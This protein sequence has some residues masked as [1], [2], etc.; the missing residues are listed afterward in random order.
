MPDC[1]V[2]TTY[3]GG[4][5]INEVVGRPIPDPLILGP[6]PMQSESDFRQVNGNLQVA[7]EMEWLTDFSQAERIGMTVRLPL[8]QEQARRGFDLVLALGLR[9][10][11]E[12]DGGQRRL[13]S[14]FEGHHY[15]DGLSL[16]PQG[17]PTNNTDDEK[18]GFD[19]VALEET[20]FRVERSRPL[21][22][23]EQEDFRK[24]DGQRLAE[25][26]GIDYGVLQH[27]NYSDGFDLRDAIAM[28][29][30]L[31][32]ASLGYFMEEM[33][34]PVFKLET[35][36]QTRHFFTRFVSGRGALPAIRVG[37]QPYGVLPVSVFSRWRWSKTQDGF[38]D[39]LYQVLKRLDQTWSDLSREVAHAGASADH[40]KELLKILGLQ[41]SSV[42]F[43][44]RFAVGPDYVW[45]W[46]TFSGG[47]RAAPV[48]NRM[49][50]EAAAELLA[51]LGYDFS[52]TPRILNLS[53]LRNQTPLN[54]PLIDDAL[55]SETQRLKPISETIGNY[56]HWLLNSSIDAIRE[57]D[58]GRDNQGNPR[59]PPTALLYLMLRHALTLDYWDV[60]MK[61]HVREKTVSENGRREAELLNMRAQPDVSR[62]DYFELADPQVTGNLKM[63]DFLQTE[64]GSD[65]EEA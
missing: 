14:L 64:R 16:V 41:A 34:R 19:S 29:R 6:D 9:L 20:S 30:A 12:A 37:H 33:M 51:E 52:E 48:W 18:S 32:P 49:L 45:N 15:T 40:E 57:Q 23:V 53:F 3:A 2:I 1:F 4:E 10:S 25:A 35:I 42:E 7:H 38:L 65:I 56:I 62:W 63:K 27:I 8:T 11:L 55:L 44:Q 59:T 47:R 24:R 61:L 50:A 43:Y 22:E 31:W 26:L 46:G 58:F 60:A 39:N 36:R 17:T 28:N 54:G 5:K 21:F 13:E